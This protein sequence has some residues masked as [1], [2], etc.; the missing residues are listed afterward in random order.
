MISKVILDGTPITIVYMY[1]RTHIDMLY[2]H[3]YAHTHIDMYTFLCICMC[4]K[5]KL[6]GHVIYTL[7]DIIA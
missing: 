7:I 4:I 6:L 2:T 3:I 1:A 5:I